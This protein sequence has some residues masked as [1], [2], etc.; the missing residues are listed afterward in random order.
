MNRKYV[1]LEP[2]FSA[3]GFE[4]E[5]QSTEKYLRKYPF[6]LEEVLITRNKDGVTMVEPYYLLNQIKKIMKRLEK[7]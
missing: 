7:V 5:I 1:L 3:K 2:A 6:L 4:K